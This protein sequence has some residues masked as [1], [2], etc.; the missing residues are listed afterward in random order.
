MLIALIHPLLKSEHWPLSYPGNSVTQSLIKL[1][2]ISSL[3]YALHYCRLLTLHHLW[4][5]LTSQAQYPQVRRNIPIC[6]T[7]HKTLQNFV[8]VTNAVMVWFKSIVIQVCHML[9]PDHCALARNVF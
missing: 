5:V 9:L 6:F 3:H 7:F 8:R 2:V 4:L 1:V